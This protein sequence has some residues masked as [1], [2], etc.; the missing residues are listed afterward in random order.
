MIYLD[1]TG[2]CRLPLQTGIPRA[3]R[4]LHALLERSGIPVTP[5]VWQPFR[6]G[7]T[8]LSPR[9]REL[10]EGHLGINTGKDAK[11][12]PPPRDD[13]WPYLKS[14]LEDLIL[15]NPKPKNLK[16]MGRDETLLVTSLFPD[17]RVEYLMGMMGHTGRCMAIFH[18]GIP[19]SDPN[20]GKWAKG[21]HVKSLQLL[22]QMHLVICVSQSAEIE[23]KALW[24]DHSIRGTATRAIVWPV[25]FLGSRPDWTEPG[26][27]PLS[28]LYVARLKK[29]KNHDL[30]FSAC[31]MLWR[32]GI[33][34][35]LNL[36]GCEDVAGESKAIQARIR[37]LQNAGYPIRWMGHVSDEVLDKAYRRS[38]FTVFP[39]LREGL[40]LPV[41]E[42]LWHGRPVI[43]GADGPMA[44]IGKG[45]GCL[46][47]EMQS[48]E[49]LA[50]AMRSLLND[51]ARNLRIAREAYERPLKTWD[52]YGKELLPILQSGRGGEE[53]Q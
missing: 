51:P 1:V 35:E 6:H 36:I 12:E 10:L 17:N 53:R 37:I 20:V 15:R 47:A 31:E 16:K 42:S 24:E 22:A 27:D 32:E 41:L 38:T 7:Y 19:L 5:V 11:Q 23:L 50:T 52:E 14:C 2:G 21:R 26:K 45:A 40:G 33:S 39:S 3:T 9:G 43:T 44:E 34:F 8:S 30:L 25:P 48:V 13:T 18:D 29:T 49:S 46:N 4:A 28:V